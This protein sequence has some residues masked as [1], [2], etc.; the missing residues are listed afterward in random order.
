MP[1]RYQEIFEARRTLPL[2]KGAIPRARGSYGALIAVMAPMDFLMLTTLNA[3]QHD[4]ISRAAVTSL[5]DYNDNESGDFNKSDHGGLPYLNV[6][7]PS[8]QITGH[9]GRHRAAMVLKAGGTSFPVML[10]FHA[11][12]QYAVTYEKYDAKEDVGE[13]EVEMFADIATAEQR[14]AEIIAFNQDDEQPYSYHGIKV[15]TRAGATLK[16]QPDRS[17]ASNW[18]HAAWA[19]SDMPEYLIGQYRPIK[20]PASHMRVGIVKGYNHF[21]R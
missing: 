14:A 11:D 13:D 15:R 16:G 6:G 7:Y 17:D 10:Y 21:S 12:T 5:D 2:S 1:M 8:G 20:I 3:A 4:E 18:K 19:P 9:E